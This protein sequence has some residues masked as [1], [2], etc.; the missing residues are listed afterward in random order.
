MKVLWLRP[1]TGEN[2]SVRRRRIASHLREMGVE[3][4]LR[5]ASGT[6]L[7]GAIWR[8]LTSDHDVIV[9]N[10][11]VGL[12]IGYP[13]AKLL[14]TPFVGDVSDPITDI[15]GLPE[16]LYR[17]FGWYEL[18]VLSRADATVFV[19]ESSLQ[20]ARE[21][22]IDGVKLPNAVDYE[23]FANPNGEIVEEARSIL[24]DAGVRLDRPIA[25][26]IGSLV[27]HY[28]ITEI[29][30]AAEQTPEW[31]FVFVGEGNM[32]Q[33]VSDA[34]AGRSNVHFP[35]AFEY[36]LMPG[37]LSHATVGLCLADHEQPL[38]LRE[39]GAAGLATIAP[40]GILTNWYEEDELVFVEPTPEEIS[41]AFQELPDGRWD[42]FGENLK[43][44]A[45]EESWKSIAEEYMGLFEEIYP[46]NNPSN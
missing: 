22:G 30:E 1:S 36:D 12:Y 46:A 20:R 21:H 19:H 15:D 16:P 42:K 43:A 31:E 39:Y 18:Q 6:D 9:G 26:Y 11:R 3:V 4:E 17:F 35:G 5:D 25:I 23:S 2:V 24:A 8:A 40:R 37:F 44:R 32:G 14:R 41:A 7:P 27:P 28:H 29:L 34:A 45:E 38:K 10:V 33:E 13:L